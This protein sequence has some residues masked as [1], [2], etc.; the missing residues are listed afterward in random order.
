MKL[1]PYPILPVAP[2]SV[3][4]DEQLGS[5]RKFWFRYGDKRWLFKDPRPGTG[6]HWAEKIAA[7][8][9]GLIG[10]NAA[11]VEL[12]EIE[13][14]PGSAGLSFIEDRQRQILIH[15]NEL[16][17]GLVTG[18]DKD[19][20][21]RQSDHTMENI[22]LGMEAVFPS[23]R[24]RE[25]AAL[26]LSGCVVLDALV[27][28]TDRHHENWGILLHLLEPNKA[29]AEIAPSFDHASSLGRELLDAERARRLKE[30]RVAHYIENGRGGIFRSSADKHGL[31]PIATAR[32]LAE[33][34]PAFFAPWR[35]RLAK[36]DAAQFST[37]VNRV[38]DAWMSPEAR[39][40]A[41][42]MLRISHRML[43]DIPS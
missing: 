23:G 19:K 25:V 8:V 18:Y 43:L 29:R 16:L 42:E 27:G 2:G 1:D 37:I 32:R 26:Q 39:R 40:F 21:F 41:E 30:N 15:G 14:R 4:D 12:A 10:L 34:Y 33:N 35:D 38:P 11:R 36:V 5:K 7:E 17:G 6:E 13:G 9:A 31:S 24:R 3:E 22:I 20:K 28:N